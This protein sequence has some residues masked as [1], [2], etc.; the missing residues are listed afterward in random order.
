MEPFGFAFIVG[1]SIVVALLAVLGIVR[2]NLK[3]CQPNEVLIFS[4]RRR[5]LSDGSKSGVSVH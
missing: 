4:G 3:I 2:S 1:G 5:R